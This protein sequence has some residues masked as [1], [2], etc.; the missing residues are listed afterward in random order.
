MPSIRMRSLVW[1]GVIRVSVSP[2]ATRS[3]I[4]S[5][6]CWGFFLEGAVPVDGALVLALLT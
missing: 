2:S 5:S 1:R 3:M 6:I 4:P